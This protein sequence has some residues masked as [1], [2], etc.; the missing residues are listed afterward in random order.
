MKSSA[1]HASHF[2]ALALILV[3]AGIGVFVVRSMLQ[4]RDTAEE[5]SRSAAISRAYDEARYRITAVQ[6]AAEQHL[7]QPTPDHRQAFDESVNQAIL[8]LDHVSEV[9]TA[10]DK[11]IVAA[12]Y[13]SELPA[14]ESVKRIFL[15]IETGQ[16]ITDAIPDAETANRIL[17]TLT[18]RA[19]DRQAS[20]SQDLEH[21]ITEQKGNVRITIAVC[22]IGLLLVLALL[23][24]FQAFGRREALQKA[25]LGRLRTAALTDSLTGLGNHRSFQEEL[26]RQVA[27]SS[28]HGEQLALA[29]IDVD[30][31]KDVNDTW[32]HARGDQVLRDT[33]RLLKDFS[34]A[35]DYAFRIG[36]DEFA[37]ILPHTDGPTAGRVMDQ[38]R[39]A[40]AK[41]FKDG[42]TISAGIA[43]ANDCQGD[44]T[45]LRQQADSALYE[46]KLRG[47]NACVQFTPSEGARPVFPA[48]KINALRKL[49]HDGA[50]TAAFQPIWN[51]KS[52]S[53]LA[54]EALARIPEE[55]DI[56]GPQLAFDIA[57]R[58][59]KC[60]EL[61]QVC[62]KAILE[63]APGIPEGSLLFVNVSPY[64]LTHATFSPSAIVEEFRVAGFD[65]ARVVLEITERSSVAVPII[66]AA[67]AEL[68]EAGFKIALDDV[69]AGNA[70]LEMLRR[71]PV[72]YVKIDRGV[73]LSALR[74][75]MG[76]A[77]V[78]AIVAF[79]SQAGALVVAEGIEDD[80]MM[81]LVRW[82]ASGG[83][84]QAE[85]MIYAVQGYLLGY[86]SA[87]ITAEE[88]SNQLAA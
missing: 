15:A 60:A 63:R 55:F 34:R 18:P 14:L 69:G 11:A 86:P 26:R 76:R 30:E 23:V 46:A 54:H 8:A 3:I 41:V 50:M 83:D 10:E 13:Q 42:P 72:E 88:K 44:E 20:A 58:I 33:A 43:N 52:G 56:S 40:I 38:L 84:D 19:N 71:V 67:V 31:F 85:S 17:S 66:E 16:P 70:G 61:D 62:R 32:G 25:E 73:I 78:M 6:L 53:L 74:D 77:A 36:G 37:M 28:R 7:R 75:T 45:V 29:L 79:A 80:A 68:R 59:G 2:A 64:T 81:D 9:G 57:E 1:R 21:L 4:T 47:R 22:A 5:V 48:A 35:E 87:E 82:I 39:L 12:L 24:A 27:R 49:I 51:L 65:P